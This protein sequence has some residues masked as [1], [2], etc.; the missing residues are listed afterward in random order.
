MRANARSCA[1]GCAGCAGTTCSSDRSR[2]S[3]CAERFTS[4]C[5]SCGRQARE[6]NRHANKPA[7]KQ[8]AETET[9]NQ[10]DSRDRAGNAAGNRIVG[11]TE[12]EIAPLHAICLCLYDPALCGPLRIALGSTLRGTRMSDQGPLQ[13]SGAIWYPPGNLARRRG[14]RKTFA[15]I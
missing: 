11:T 2:F 4:H 8:R 14:T 6:T 12:Q 10:A 9:H 1:W 3:R 13:A 5:L 15:L 7:N